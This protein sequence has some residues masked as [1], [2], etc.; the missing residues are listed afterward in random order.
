MMDERHNDVMIGYLN[1]KIE[2]YPLEQVME[3]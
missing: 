3:D 2:S 1:G